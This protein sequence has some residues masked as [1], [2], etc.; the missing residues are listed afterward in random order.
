MLASGSWPSLLIDTIS[1]L[2][3]RHNAINVEHGRAC[4]LIYRRRV[5]H[6]SVGY[7]N[8]IALRSGEWLPILTLSVVH[9]VVPL[10]L[11][12]RHLPIVACTLVLGEL[13]GELCRG[14]GVYRHVGGVRDVAVAVCGVRIG[15][16][17]ARCNDNLGLLLLRV[18][19][20]RIII[21]LF[22][23]FLSLGGSHAALLA[24]H[25]HTLL[26]K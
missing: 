8:I 12:P 1:F 2:L 15:G 6:C 7:G 13:L 26:I 21:R 9:I 4:M 11:V 3:L 16:L 22:N 19:L 20:G 17:G 10:R 18:I 14:F 25:T 24:L 5:I 23:L